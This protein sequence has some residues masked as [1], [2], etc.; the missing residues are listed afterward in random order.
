MQKNHKKNYI[1]LYKFMLFLSRHNNILN[2][3]GNNIMDTFKKAVANLAEQLEQIGSN[4]AFFTA[5]AK[6]GSPDLKEQN[7]ENA[8]M[9]Q[10]RYNQTLTTVVAIFPNIDKRTIENALFDI[11]Y[12]AYSKEYSK[13]RLWLENVYKETA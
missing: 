10:Q 11:Y 4:E 6:F 5:H 13:R 9:L 2:N 8:N 12:D 1:H 7:K 3:T